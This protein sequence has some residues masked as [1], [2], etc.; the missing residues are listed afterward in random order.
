MVGTDSDTSILT[1]DPESTTT[2]YESEAVLT[3]QI[4]SQMVIVGT[5]RHQIQSNWFDISADT[6]H[7]IEKMMRGDMRERGIRRNHIER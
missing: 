2:N 4:T 7:S 5:E 3:I 1:G 6:I